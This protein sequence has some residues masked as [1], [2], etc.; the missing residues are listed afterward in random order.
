MTIFR[1]AANLLDSF[2]AGA[3]QALTARAAWNG[4]QWGS[5]VGTEFTTNATPTVCSPNVANASGNKSLLTA[6][7]SFAWATWTAAGNGDSHW[8][9][10]RATGSTSFSG[11][12]IGFNGNTNSVTLLRVVAAASTTIGAAFTVTTT[13]PFRIAI[14]VYGS[15][16]QAWAQQGATGA[17]ISTHNVTDDVITGAGS[18]AAIRY[19]PLGALGSSVDEVGGGVLSTE[20]INLPGQMPTL[21]AAAC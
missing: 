10:T 13:M 18:V 7:D 5:A 3:N 14:S 6:V 4:V 9:A 21:V 20:P 2:N 16:V 8:L 17:W 15:N 19:G 12:V 1:G 11:Y